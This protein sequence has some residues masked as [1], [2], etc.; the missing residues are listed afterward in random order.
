MH[1]IQ[2]P[3]FKASVA[4]RHMR[5][6]DLASLQAARQAGAAVLNEMNLHAGMLAP[7]LD[8]KF[9]QE[10]FDNMGRSAD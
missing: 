8:Q 3:T 10:C 4:P 6:L 7:I 9:R 2:Q 1:W 5:D